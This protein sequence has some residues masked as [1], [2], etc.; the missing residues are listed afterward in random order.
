MGHYTDHLRQTAELL[1]LIE[2]PRQ[3]LTR[4]AMVTGMSIAY[5]V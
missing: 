1:D 3:I 2:H 5:F 4:D